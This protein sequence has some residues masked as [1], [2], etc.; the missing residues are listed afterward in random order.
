MIAKTDS[1]EAY[2]GRY[3][4]MKTVPAMVQ[5]LT[6]NRPNLSTCYRWAERGIAGVLLEVKCIG[7]AVHTRAE[8]LEAFFDQTTE[9]KTGRRP[10]AVAVAPARAVAR[11]REAARRNLQ[12]AG[13]A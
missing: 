2:R 8:W 7:A 11:D 12:E 5:E 6:G 10:G 9:V 13:I 4:P 3:V 1:L